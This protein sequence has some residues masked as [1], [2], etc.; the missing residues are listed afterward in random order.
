MRIDSASQPHRPLP[1]NQFPLTD[2]A[3]LRKGGGSH[4]ASRRTTTFRSA[5]VFLGIICWWTGHRRG[6]E[7]N[8]FG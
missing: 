8:G 3:F 6:L 7:A 1:Q 4:I 5:G 2:S